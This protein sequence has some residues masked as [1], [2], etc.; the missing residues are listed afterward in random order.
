M[1][2][3]ERERGAEGRAHGRTDR[4]TGERERER[5]M[6]EKER[7]RRERETVQ[8]GGGSRFCLTH[9]QDVDLKYL[10]KHDLK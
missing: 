8:L 6:E 4:R 7:E 1:E 9:I 10:L 5:E 2:R 3:R